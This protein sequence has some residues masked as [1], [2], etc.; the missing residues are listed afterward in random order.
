MFK[1][2]AIGKEFIE[3]AKKR[4]WEKPKKETGNGT[5]WNR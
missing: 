3:E 4:N 2:E 5:G 1:V